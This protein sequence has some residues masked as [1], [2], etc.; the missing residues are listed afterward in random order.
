MTSLDRGVDVCLGF[1]IPA[2]AAALPG[3]TDRIATPLS[4]SVGWMA[5]KER[6]SAI[7]SK[8]TLRF[9]KMSLALPMVFTRHVKAQDAHVL[10]PGI[11]EVNNEAD[12]DD[13]HDLLDDV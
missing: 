12:T 2:V 7:S 8:M 13:K 10:Y 9:V 6:K 4:W 5:T 1:S 11:Y 3:S